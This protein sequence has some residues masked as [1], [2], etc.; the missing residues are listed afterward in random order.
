MDHEV[1]DEMT[2]GDY[3]QR[4]DTSSDGWEVGSMKWVWDQAVEARPITSKVL[5]NFEIHNC[6]RAKPGK[7]RS[8][9]WNN[10]KDIRRRVD[11]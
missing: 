7:Y 4:H 1:A 10:A 5:A 11:L 6:T 3:R 9:L 8:N 2:M